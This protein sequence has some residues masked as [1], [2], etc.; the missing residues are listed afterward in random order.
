MKMRAFFCFF[1]FSLVFAGCGLGPEKVSLDDQRLAPMLKA[2]AVVDRSS[3]GFTA[4]S[5]EA[6]VRVEWAPRDGYDAMLHVYA[7]SSRTIAFKKSADGE[8]RWIGE[9]EIHTGPNQYETVDGRVSEQIVISF[10]VESVTGVPLNTVH[11]Q[12]LGEDAR[13]AWPKKITLHEA[14]QVIEEW[15]NRPNKSLQPTATAVTPPA[16]Q[17]IVPAVAVAE[18]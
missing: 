7:G 14:K 8:F 9:Q 17:E 18:H 12:Y 4:I 6:D 1:S 3:L 5:P 11:V 16:A 15:Q 2:M 13:L 10:E